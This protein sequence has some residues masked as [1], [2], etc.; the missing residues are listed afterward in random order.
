MTSP[1]ETDPVAADLLWQVDATGVVRGVQVAARWQGRL[2]QAA[3]VGRHWAEIVGEVT[4]APGEKTPVFPVR[5]LALVVDPG[6]EAGGAA[7][8]LTEGP[9]LRLSAPDWPGTGSAAG[10]EAGDRRWF[11]LIP[12]PLPEGGG[13]LVG[14]DVT[15]TRTLRLAQERR[16]WFDELIAAVSAAAGGQDPASL[17]AA[18]DLLLERVGAFLGAMEGALYQPGGTETA[19]ERVRTWPAGAAG[20]WQLPETVAADD[21]PWLAP[22][23]REGRPARAFPLPATLAASGPG[24]AGP[25]GPVPVLSRGGG[26]P[27]TPSV[28]GWLLVPLV[29]GPTASGFLAFLVADLSATP[30]GDLDSLRILGDLLAGALERRQLEAYRAQSQER[31]NGILNSLEDAVW[32]IDPQRSTLLFV[33]PVAERILGRSMVELLAN[34]GL[35]FEVAHPDDR[36]LVARWREEVEEAGQAEFQYRILRPDGE[37]RW[38]FVRLWMA[39]SVSGAPDRI[40]GIATDIT[41]R[42]EAEERLRAQQN[43]LTNLIE[44]LQ[45]GILVT[46]GQR[47][48]KHLN[49]QFSRLFR[50]SEGAAC[51]PATAGGAAAAPVAIPATIP[52]ASQDEGPTSGP[53]T[54]SAAGQPAPVAGHEAGSEAGPGAEPPADLDW[55]SLVAQRLAFGQDEFLAHLEELMGARRPEIGRELELRGGQ[56]LEQDFIPLFVDDVFQGHVWQ[57]RDITPRKEAARALQAARQKEV[58]IAGKIQQ[59]LLIGQPPEGLRGAQ[60]ASM[61]IPSGGVDGDFYDFLLHSPTC[62]DLVIG[63]V[64]GKG[65]PA[66]LIGAAAKSAFLRALARLAR[67]GATPGPGSPATAGRVEPAPS[68]GKAAAG[69]DAAGSAAAPPGPGVPAPAALTN[70]AHRY[71]TRQLIHLQRFLT[72]CFARFDL[73]ARRLTFVDAGHTKALHF[74]PATGRCDWLAADNSP[75]GFDEDEVYAEGEAALQEGDILVFYSDGLTEAANPAG[76]LFETE[77]L[78]QAIRDLQGLPPDHLLEALHQRV[79]DFTGSRTFD[80]DLTVVVVRIAQET[81]AGSGSSCAEAEFAA[82]LGN[83]APLREFIQVTHDRAAREILDPDRLAALILAASE[84]AANIVLH[85]LA[86]RAEA[87]LRIQVWTFE[88]RLEVWLLYDGPE[89]TPPVVSEPDLTQGREGGLGLYIIREAVDEV[90]YDRLDARTARLALIKFAATPGR[91]KEP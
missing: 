35:W 66:A 55:G 51:P 7:D 30:V 72:L 27:P 56:T 81:P 11:E 16:R 34:P 4:P 87:R 84:G 2:P 18:V 49:R 83:L 48:L 85:G 46:D 14:R 24:T 19:Y 33:N 3:W 50:A 63:D 9:A 54:P 69:T 17:D 13:V 86:G 39:F 73:E 74:H 26:A 45:S 90:V 37:R 79:V 31:L 75:L 38:L 64:M 62:F 43:L 65:I 88:D 36:P 61:T 77:R 60:V 5:R 12:V 67:D 80:D 82:D 15:E 32:A 6:P 40:D 41:T 20:G 71:L 59:T 1:P 70:L 58:E 22:I 47:R 28:A 21:F 29:A 68:G 23:L 8:G 91:A 10:A 53:E 25:A 44:N 57:F 78:E 42:V 52:A 89:F 76:D